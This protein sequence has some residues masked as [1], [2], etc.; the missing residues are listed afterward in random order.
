MQLVS[1]Q[2]EGMRNAGSITG[3]AA[4]ALALLLPIVGDASDGLEHLILEWTLVSKDAGPRLILQYDLHC[5]STGC[6]LTE[7]SLGGCVPGSSGAHFWIRAHTVRSATGDLK[8][9]RGVDGITLTYSGLDET[10]EQKVR[11]KTRSIVSKV[12]SVGVRL[13]PKQ[14][15]K[16]VPDRILEALA[17]DPIP[18]VS[19]EVR[20]SV[21]MQ[22]GPARIELACPVI[23]VPGTTEHP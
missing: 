17:Q 14:K 15:R 6:D 23:Q 11:F 20:N 8:V 19:E 1:Q 10:L 18:G 22:N 21:S 16:D 5:W 4:A 2:G 3:A 13:T 7:V 12:I 9:V